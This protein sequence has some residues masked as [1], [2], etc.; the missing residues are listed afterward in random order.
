MT[1]YRLLPFLQ[2]E[3]KGARPA[4]RSEDGWDR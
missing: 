2:R 4:K 3:K 1:A